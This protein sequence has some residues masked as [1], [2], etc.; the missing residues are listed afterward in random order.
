VR[1]LHTLS[2]AFALC[3]VAACGG[4]GGGG[5]IGD[6]NAGVNLT[7]TFDEVATITRT[8]G[9]CTEQVGDIE[10]NERTFAHDPVQKTLVSD[11]G[12]PD[13]LQAQFEKSRATFDVTFDEPSQ[14]LKFTAHVEVVFAADGQSYAGNGR[15]TVTMNGTTCAYEYRIEGKRKP[16]PTAGSIAITIDATGVDLAPTF[17]LS[18]DGG[19][20]ESVAAI[21]SIEFPD[22]AAGFY[23]LEL[24]VPEDEGY[25]VFP[26]AQRVVEV[27]AGE[28]AQVEFEVARPTTARAWIDFEQ[29]GFVDVTGNGHDGISV[30]ALPLE[31]V[32]AGPNNGSRS[33]RFDGVVARLDLKR[34]SDLRMNADDAFT[35]SVWARPDSVTAGPQVLLA[36]SPPA[37]AVTPA[38]H[39]VALFLDGAVPTHD[40]FFVAAVT[41]A[42]VPAG[43]WRHY[44]VTYDG[45]GVHKLFVDGVM[46]QHTFNAA[47]EGDNGEPAWALS[48]GE[49]HN[50]QFP[51]GA[52]AGNLDE[53]SFF[54]RALADDEV[55]DLMTNGPTGL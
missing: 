43:Q 3:A 39:T 53:F 12:T 40:N 46:T 51:G 7:G 8:E 18:F 4:G 21:D 37:L 14:G 10:L 42:P 19:L 32:T 31:S 9:P 2:L 24:F 23:E 47:N 20:P 27:V 16:T 44:A 34:S 50:F 45:A 48:L 5:A 35:W 11:P 52:F 36:K 55:L 1:G 29:S 41:G 38:V 30:G 17:M 22:L 49:G 54:Q 26:S 33:G 28:V 6:L 15:D 13:A 25:F